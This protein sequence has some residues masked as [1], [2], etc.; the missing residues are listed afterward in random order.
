MNWW[1]SSRRWFLTGGV[2]GNCLPVTPFDGRWGGG[3]AIDAPSTHVFYSPTYNTYVVVYISLVRVP[4]EFIY[5]LWPP[6]QP[7]DLPT[8]TLSLF[9]RIL[10]A[11]GWLC[12]CLCIRTHNPS[13]DIHDPVIA[14]NKTTLW[15]LWHECNVP[16]RKNANVPW[17]FAERVCVCDWGG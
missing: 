8:L 9:A 12:N 1:D 17:G 14:S 2:G 6:C 4:A 10:F 13:T 11:A 5:P 7:T 3:P 15:S 16:E